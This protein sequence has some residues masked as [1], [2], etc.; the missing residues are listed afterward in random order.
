[1]IYRGTDYYYYKSNKYDY[2]ISNGSVYTINGDPYHLTYWSYIP[3]SSILFASE[4][5]FPVLLVAE[6]DPHYCSPD[7]YFMMSDE[8]SA[9]INGK[10]YNYGAVRALRELEIRCYE[11][12]K[13]KVKYVLRTKD[14][15]KLASMLAPVYMQYMSKDDVD[16][17]IYM[18]EE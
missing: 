4:Q 5:K 2:L 9:I 11:F 7:V 15:S 10:L 17:L 6:F 8:V 18:L 1:M 3:A 16:D 14:I 12:P 13:S